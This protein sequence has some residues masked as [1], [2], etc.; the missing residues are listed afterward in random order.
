MTTYSL[1]GDVGGTNARL[2]LCDI[3]TGDLSH[4]LTYSGL[5]YPS[6]EQVVRVYLEQQSIIIEQACIT[7]A[8]PIDGDKVTMTNHTWTFSI[9][10]MQ[11]N[12]GLQ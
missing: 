12:L 5:D 1:V 11:Q 6:L 4:F 9:A 10:Q 8:Y 2:G 7:I 3:E